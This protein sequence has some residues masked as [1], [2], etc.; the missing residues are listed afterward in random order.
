LRIRFAV[1]RF[2]LAVVISALIR[3][4]RGF[5]IYA[6]CTGG[7]E[8][9]DWIPDMQSRSTTSARNSKT[10]TD[11]KA[12]L[13]TLWI[14]AV[15]NYIYADVFTAMDPSA[16]GGSVRMSHGMMLGAAALM[17]TAMVMVPLS[18]FLRY[19]ANR[20]ANIVVGVMHTMAVILSLFVGGAMPAS[21][22][23]LF[24]SVEV[25]STSFIVCYAWKWHNVEIG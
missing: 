18:R 25:I 12:M 2:A 3:F 7:C 14:F 17:E 9:I 16:E 19:R 13:S 8:M 5:A 22:Y 11:R 4:G 15:M 21:Y 20:W 1:A 10:A 23:L 6:A 24:A